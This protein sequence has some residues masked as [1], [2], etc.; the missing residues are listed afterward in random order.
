MSNILENS[1][2]N[3]LNNLHLILSQEEEKK[4][5]TD[6]KDS[7]VIQT[8]T[9]TYIQDPAVQFQLSKKNLD[10]SNKQKT[11]YLNEITELNERNLQLKRDISDADIIE[12]KQNSVFETID[13]LRTQDAYKKNRAKIETIVT[14]KTADAIKKIK[15]I[16]TPDENNENVSDEEINFPGDSNNIQQITNT[17]TDREHLQKVIIYHNRTSRPHTVIGVLFKTIGG[18][19]RTDN[20][21]H[22]IIADNYIDNIKNFGQ[23]T[24]KEFCLDF[25]NKSYMEHYIYNPNKNSEGHAQPSHNNTISERTQE[26][27]EING[28]WSPASIL[29]SLEHERAHQLVS[30]SKHTDWF[31]AWLGGMRRHSS[32]WANGRDHRNYSLPQKFYRYWM[33]SLSLDDRRGSKVWY[34]LNGDPWE[35]HKWIPWNEQ[36]DGTKW[37]AAYSEPLLHM[38]KYHNG[39]YNDYWL[40]EPHHYHHYRKFIPFKRPALFSRTIMPVQTETF[41]VESNQQIVIK[42][43]KFK[44]ELK[45]AINAATINLFNKLSEQYREMLNSNNKSHKNKAQE[46]VY[47]YAKINRNNNI[48]NIINEQIN[49]L[50]TFLDNIKGLNNSQINRMISDSNIQGFSNISEDKI[51]ELIYL[52]QDNSVNII[53]ILLISILL[54]KFYCKK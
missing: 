51:S 23:R 40:V 32:F 19:Q 34:W 20:D 31:G 35:Y 14:Y 26:T 11:D 4:F 13:D 9:M 46:Y 47:N 43:G 44:S 45:T 39:T 18:T 24:G 15:V 16:Y 30:N 38:L 1:E 21:A 50:Q 37:G 29:D 48:I 6:A 8:T 42:N 53:L 5:N 27:C 3:I 41:Q 28:K 17:L 7:A 36:P 22:L 25:N 54:Y 33:N 49:S 12:A 52:I 10:S 2:P